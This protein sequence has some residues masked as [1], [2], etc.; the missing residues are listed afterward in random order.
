MLFSAGRSEPWFGN[1]L[2]VRPS[3]NSLANVAA[4]WSFRQLARTS[5]YSRSYP[6]LRKSPDLQRKLTLFRSVI[7]CVC[8]AD[9]R[10]WTR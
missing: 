9:R 7:T 2:W 3:W 5:S 1:V 8:A 10:S 4:S 6:N